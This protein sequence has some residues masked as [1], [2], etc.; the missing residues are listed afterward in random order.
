[1]STIFHPFRGFYLY[2]RDTWPTGEF[3][4]LTQHSFHFT[5]IKVFLLPNGSTHQMDCI[6]WP[7]IPSTRRKD[8][9]STMFYFRS[10][11]RYFR[12]FFPLRPHD[13]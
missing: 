2:D 5:A 6:S 4:A 10:L 8:F 7:L 3:K 12:G 11:L 1:M 13:K 9:L